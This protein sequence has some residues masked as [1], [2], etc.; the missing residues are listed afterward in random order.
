MWDIFN[1]S[2][3]KK[4][5]PKK[6]INKSYKKNKPITKKTADLSKTKSHTTVSNHEL[7]KSNQEQKS[8]TEI[9]IQKLRKEF[10]EK[11]KIID[12]LEKKLNKKP[13]IKEPISN[14][15]PSISESSKNIEDLANSFHQKYRNKTEN[16][17]SNIGEV[18]HSTPNV[19]YKNFEPVFE[20]I[21]EE[22]EDAFLG[23]L[24]VDKNNHFI[25]YTHNIEANDT[26][27]LASLIQNIE[28]TLE[29][30]SFPS[31]HKFYM[32]DL[33]KDFLMLNLLFEN[34]IYYL[35]FNKKETNLGLVLNILYDKLRQK[36]LE[37]INL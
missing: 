35:V 25:I 36:H 29:K 28:E 13:S 23:G 3:G 18:S 14:E 7:G 27:F 2:G 31:L 21:D 22:M 24:I 1:W 10:E 20:L 12:A 15:A 26:S 4:K 8:S 33:E 6:K 34:H 32:M 5:K 37:I 9:S 16:T 17:K 19:T 11:Q 30:S